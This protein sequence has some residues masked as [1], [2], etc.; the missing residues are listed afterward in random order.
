VAA[1][2]LPVTLSVLLWAA[3]ALAREPR[4]AEPRSPLE[5][6]VRRGESMGLYGRWARIAMH[7]LYARTG[8]RWNERLQVGRKLRIFV[9]DAERGSF[10]ARRAAFHK[11]REAAWQS[12]GQRAYVVRRGDNPWRIARRL[13]VPLWVLERLNAGRDLSRLTIGE[14]IQVP[15]RHPGEG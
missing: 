5:I 10:E 8:I 9:T 7:D 2:R 1:N 14:K 13:G 6:E 11:K 3:P 15:A 12:A 4:P